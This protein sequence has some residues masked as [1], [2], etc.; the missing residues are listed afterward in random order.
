MSEKRV[1]E[2]KKLIRRET[3][4][5]FH[6]ARERDFGFGHGGLVACGLIGPGATVESKELTEVPPERICARCRSVLYQ[7]GIPVG[8]S[9]EGTG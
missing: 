9:E 4:S 8:Q 2:T 3:D 5:L 7:A 1:V 6:F